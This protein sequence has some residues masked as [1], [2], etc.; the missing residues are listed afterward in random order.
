MSNIARLNNELKK[1]GMLSEKMTTSTVLP[2][3]ET[4]TYI[5]PTISNVPDTSGLRGE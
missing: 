4:Q 3:T 2:P 5:P 1:T